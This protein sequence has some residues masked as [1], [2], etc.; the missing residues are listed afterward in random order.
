M[1]SVK[2]S[3]WLAAAR[4]GTAAAD[5]RGSVVLLSPLFRNIGRELLVTSSEATVRKFPV[6]L[7]MLSSLIDSTCATMSRKYSAHASK[8]FRSLAA[9]SN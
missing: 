4:R 3:H 7:R 1:L 9:M 8:S 6:L 2:G 5:V